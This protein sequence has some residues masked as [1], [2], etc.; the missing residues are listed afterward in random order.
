M[1]ILF[2]DKSRR[3]VAAIHCGRKGLEKRIIKNLVKILY[4]RGCSREDL[5]VAIGPSISKKNY[6]VDKKIF[7]DFNKKANNKRSISFFRKN[8]NISNL[9]NLIMSKKQDL[10][11][12]DLK[13]HAY[14]QI[15]SENIP[16]KNIEISNLCTY[17]FDNE[18]YSWRKTKTIF[19][20]W[21]FICS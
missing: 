14:L 13:K 16:H 12:L 1:P 5:L 17:D 11:P 8:E 3:L 7:N 19:R 15:L 21:N 18:F 2:A 20:Q 6:L 4:K 9:K 10:I